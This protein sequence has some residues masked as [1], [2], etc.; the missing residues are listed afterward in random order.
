MIERLPWPA[1]CFGVVCRRRACTPLRAQDGTLAVRA[2]ALDA[3]TSPIERRRRKATYARRRREAQR[4]EL[5]MRDSRL[6]DM[7]RKSSRLDAP[8]PPR[9]LRA[10]AQRQEARESAGEKNIS[11][12]TNTMIYIHSR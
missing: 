5:S 2:L 6:R 9:C 7:P 3:E 1:S 10:S 8:P 11:L 12:N 4:F